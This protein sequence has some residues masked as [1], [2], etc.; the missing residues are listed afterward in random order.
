MDETKNSAAIIL[1]RSDYRENDSLLTVYTKDFGKL[2]LVARGTKK[3]SSKLSGHLEPLSLVDILIIKGKGFDYIGSAL[4]RQAFLGIK[5]D[6]NKLYFAGFALRSFNLLVRDNQL[7]ERLFFLLQRFL[8]VVDAYPED[9]FSRE[10]GELLYVFFALKLLTEL[11]YK[12]EMHECLSCRDKVKAGKNYFNLKN[13]G[14]VCPV[15]FDKDFSMYQKQGIRPAEI[16]T[17][18]DNCIKLMRFMMDSKLEDAKKLRLDKKFI[19]E[20]SILI[21][22]FINFHS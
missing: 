13:G 14:L 4:G 6:L 5:D 11:G 22:N 20:L 15:C 10:N 12:P 3:L 18:S 1:N 19:K 21:N 9:D 2:S 17:I 16:L 8:E 7:D